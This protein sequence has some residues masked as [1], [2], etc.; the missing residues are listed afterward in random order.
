MN[1]YCRMIHRMAVWWYLLS[2]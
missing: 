2:W 1:K